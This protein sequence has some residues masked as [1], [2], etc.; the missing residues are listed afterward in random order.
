MAL[1]GGQIVQVGA[2]GLVELQGPA[3]GVEDFFG[4]AGELTAF[5][6]G[7]VV[8]ADAGQQGD[9]FTAQ[10]GH[11]AVAAPEGGQA[12]LLW[13]DLGAAPIPRAQSPGTERHRRRFNLPGCCHGAA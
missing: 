9:L 2:F 5:Q 12:G 7:V 10:S 8:D 4:G 11:P 13:S 6:A 3:D 1:G